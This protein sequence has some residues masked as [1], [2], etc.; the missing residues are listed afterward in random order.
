MKTK[1]VHVKINE[2][3]EKIDT[4]ISMVERGEIFIITKEGKPIAEILPVKDKC[5]NW[6]RKIEKITLPGG[7]STQTYIEEERN[8]R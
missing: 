7:I 3:P 2:I 5:R 1:M 6:K 4:M 8:L